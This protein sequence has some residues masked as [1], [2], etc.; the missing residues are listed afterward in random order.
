MAVDMAPI[1]AFS[2][3]DHSSTPAD[4]L[5]S[6][7]PRV[8]TH[9]RAH[10]LFAK[11]CLIHPFRE[12]KLAMPTA[13]QSTRRTPT[14]SSTSRPLSARSSRRTA[15]ARSASSTKPA[16][17]SARSGQSRTTAT[18]REVERRIARF[19]KHLDD[20]SEALQLLGKDIGRGGQDAYK[21]LTKALRALRRDAQKT[22]RNLLKDFDKLRDAVTPS[23]STRRSS[24]ASRAPSNGA[25][26]T[27]RS[28]RMGATTSSRSPR[29]P[30]KQTRRSSATK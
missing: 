19:E 26:A 8:D 13:K 30:A 1:L 11:L 23:R 27:A 3:A 6:L 24:A 16:R 29:S 22:N 9:L 15:P 5:T 25:G 2:V 17:S 7:R 28:G 14:A 18:R 12:F 21:E 10:R 4:V 20:A